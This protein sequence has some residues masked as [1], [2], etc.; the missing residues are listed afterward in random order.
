MPNT[1][2]VNCITSIQ[3]LS[4]EASCWSFEDSKGRKRGPYSFAELYSWPHY[5]YLSDSSM[6]YHAENKC[7]PFTSLSML[8]TWQADRHEINSLSDS[9]YNETEKLRD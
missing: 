7:G 1:E 6:I 4:G 5:E 9:K 8:N 2:I 3:N